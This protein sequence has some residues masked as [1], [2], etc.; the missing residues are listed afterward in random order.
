MARLLLAVE[1][2]EHALKRHRLDAPL[3]VSMGFGDCA[4]LLFGFGLV[5][6]GRCLKS[7]PHRVL[8][9]SQ[10][11]HGGVHAFVGQF[12]HKAVQIGSCLGRRLR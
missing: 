2:G 7:R 11:D 10:Q 3:T 12:V 1:P 8:G 6:K 5:V 4:T 9:T